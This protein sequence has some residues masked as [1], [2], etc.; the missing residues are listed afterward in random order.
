MNI[1]KYLIYSISM[2]V[3]IVSI[4]LLANL[5][6]ISSSNNLVKSIQSIA[7]T[8]NARVGVAIKVLESKESYNI[9]GNDHFPM[10]STYKFPIA[11][12]ALQE[13]TTLVLEDSIYIERRMLHPNT[14]SPLRELYPDGGIKLTLS[15]II[16]YMLQRSDNNACDIILE[17]IGG[18]QV[19]DN[20][21][22]TIGINDIKIESSELELQSNWEVQ[23]RNWATPL[24]FIS[25]LELFDSGKLLN[26]ENQLFV[27]TTMAN[28]TSGSAKDIIPKDIIVAH[29]TGFSGVNDKGVTAA[30]NDIGIMVLPNGKRVAYA[31]FISDSL[32]EQSSNY[33]LIAQIVSLIYQEF[34]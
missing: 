29:K 27:F 21:L 1:V 25:L 26:R 24:E 3:I 32:E 33:R 17:L 7:S 14:W 10:Q 11:L 28:T 31:I 22:R 2:R 16:E 18:A 23:F 19:A 12:A 34:R 9:A 15:S 8:I 6:N 20:Y 5:I 30:N 4:M 13:G